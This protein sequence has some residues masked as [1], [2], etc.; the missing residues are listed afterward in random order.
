MSGMWDIDEEGNIVWRE[1]AT[2][3]DL[4]GGERV[5]P[6]GIKIFSEGSPIGQE[7]LRG[8]AVG[9]AP[10]PVPDWQLP[11]LEAGEQYLRDLE[12]ARGVPPTG[13]RGSG[14]DFYRGGGIPYGGR[15]EEARDVLQFE[16]DAAADED[17]AAALAAMFADEGGGAAGGAGGYAPSFVDLSSAEAMLPLT[18]TPEEQ[19]AIE[20]L[21]ADLEA[22][23]QAG[24]AAVR[25][26]WEGVRAVNQAAADKARRMAVEAGPE[27]ARLWIDAANNALNFARQ[28]GEY[29]SNLAGM[30]SVDISPTGGARNIAALLAAQAPRARAFA[31]RMGMAS[32]EDIASQA[33]TASMM[34]EA[35]AG[36]ITRTVIMEAQRAR[37]A[38]NE[39]VLSRIAAN[40]QTIAGMRASAAATNAQ[41]ANQAAQFAASQA[42][43]NA[44]T[45]EQRVEAVLQFYN[46]VDQL[47][48]NPR[49]AGLLM[50]AYPDLTPSAAESILEAQRQGTL[51]RM[52]AEGLVEAEIAAAT[53]G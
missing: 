10:P 14:R 8:R 36:D 2:R 20:S 49:G 29:F 25:S 50:R 7:I 32:A 3:S 52:R 53:R 51:D 19:A 5:G 21:L 23:G 6:W 30:Q 12:R 15:A 1:G 9:E 22:R 42:A 4:T 37:A 44:R 45:P 38:H 33:R 46:L 43:A 26:G 39:R 27:A 40:Q 34:G 47:A 35:F 28:T 17:L 24:I 16:A 13:G 41:I 31:E 18:Q 11:Q 48:V